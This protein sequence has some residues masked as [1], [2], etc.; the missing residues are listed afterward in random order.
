MNP[1]NQAD[2]DFQ[3]AL[4]ALL[5]D[6]KEIQESYL[7]QFSDMVPSELKSLLDAW[8][9]IPLS[10]KLLL[11]DQLNALADV[12]TLVSFDDL[13]IALLADSDAP[14][15]QRAVRL[16]IECEEERLIPTY[17]DMLANDTE[18]T[19][20]AETATTLGLFVLLGEFEEISAESQK[21]VVDALMAAANADENEPNIRRR[22]LES[23]GFSSRME[24]PT[25]IQSAFNRENPD[26]KASALF[27]MGQSQFFLQISQKVDHLGL[28]RHVQ[29]RYGLITNNQ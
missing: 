6:E 1:T 19:V 4:E 26:W 16:L 10:R 27:A 28:D 17:L 8:P 25:L 11:L 5:T 21:L 3:S 12:N 29:C 9:R 15:R 14:V 18:T 23:L 20:R 7:L 22:A 24:V 2:I 13:G